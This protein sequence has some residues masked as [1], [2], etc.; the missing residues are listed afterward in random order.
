MRHFKFM[1]TFD[2]RNMPILS[3]AYARRA[4]FSLR[5]ARKQWI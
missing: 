5:E 2:M 1:F 3:C 4:N